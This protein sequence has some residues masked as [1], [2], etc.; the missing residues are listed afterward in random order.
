M[1]KS[2]ITKNDTL[3]NNFTHPNSSGGDVTLRREPATTYINWI[4]ACAKRVQYRNKTGFVTSPSVKTNG[5]NRLTEAIPVVAGE[6]QPLFL[7]PR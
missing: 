1:S 7:K 3:E 5:K 6:S 4:T 2:S